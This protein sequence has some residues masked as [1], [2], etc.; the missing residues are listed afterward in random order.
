MKKEKP[1]LYTHAVIDL[2]LNSTDI[3]RK[4]DT[5]LSSLHGI[6]FTEYMVLYQLVNSPANT[7]RRID[8]A[9]SIGRTASGVTRML[10]PMEKIGL[11]KKEDNPRDARVSLV[12]ITKA[13]E[14]LFYDASKTVDEKASHLLRR[15]NQKSLR[16][17]LEVLNIIRGE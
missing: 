15:V 8:L 7:L 1:P 2:W 12:K 6:G 4:I 10:A 17:L 9:D 16:S 3:T 5:G 11:I 13:G 14:K